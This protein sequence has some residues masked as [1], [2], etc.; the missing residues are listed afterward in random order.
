M[1][2]HQSFVSLSREHHD[3]LLLATRLQQGNTALLRL[4][5]HELRWQAEYVVKFFD[6]LLA[7]H[8]EE[9]EEIVFPYA[10]EYL[11]EHKRLID[12]LIAEHQEMRKMI[13]VLRYPQERNLEHTLKRFGT[14]L[15]QHIRS[16]ERTLFP[17]CEEK[18]PPELLS[19]IGKKLQQ[20]TDG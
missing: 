18:L 1:K 5:S 16:E 17:L 11:G 4:W 9:E 15:E 12:R 7:T 10:K 6:D 13:D 2:R 3:G 8:F 20:P 19:E 14:L